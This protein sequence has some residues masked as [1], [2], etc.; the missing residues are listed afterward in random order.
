MAR[1]DN[2][3][4]AIVLGTGGVGSAALY[5]LAKRG[6]RA[7]GLDRHPP[8]HDRGSSHGQTRVIRQA[9]FEHPDYVPLAIAAYDLWSELEERHGR[10]LL[11]QTG[12]L[13]AGPADGLVIS[14]VVKS[15]ETHDLDVERFSATEAMKRFPQFKIPNGMEA[16]FEKAAGYLLVE[17]CVRANIAEAIKLDAVWKQES[18]SAWYDKGDSVEVHTEAGS[19]SADKLIV[20]AGPWART[21][22][23]SIHQQLT[24]VAKHMH[25]FDAGAPM[26]QSE[27]CPVYLFETNEGIHYGFP[28]LDGSTAK[29]AEHSGGILVEDSVVAFPRDVDLD[30]LQRVTRFT[31]ACLPFIATDVRDSAVCFYTMSPDEH[32]LL[33]QHPNHN[34][35]LIAAGLSGHGFK[36]TPVLGKALVDLAMAG[37]TKL[38]IEFLSPERF[39]ENS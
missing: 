34:N 1:Q 4:E 10:Q 9:Y 39:R 5:E 21:A 26:N 38:P 23:P 6:H 13:Q 19:Y 7:L 2:H 29:V 30:D 28:S 31:E 32:F 36:F 8:G 16:V 25:W 17:D 37:T 24:V 18:A 15:S 3:F 11:W 33:G 14:G 12:L 22:L 27:R 35:V 20:A